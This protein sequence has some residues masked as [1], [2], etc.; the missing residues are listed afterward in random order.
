MLHVGMT[1]RPKSGP[2]T[3]TM[4]H[5]RT[6]TL[7]LVR[8]IAPGKSTLKK[9]KAISLDDVSL[10]SPK[11]RW[12]TLRMRQNNQ[13]KHTKTTMPTMTMVSSQQ[14]LFRWSTASYH[15]LISS[16]PLRQLEKY[17]ATSRT[18]CKRQQTHEIK[19]CTQLQLPQNSSCQHPKTIEMA[20]IS[21]CNFWLSRGS[22]P[23][24]FCEYSNLRR[25]TTRSQSYPMPQ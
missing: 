17:G 4:D 24:D 25:S 19:I 9:K 21:I 1:S 12:W 2:D 22:F 14:S 11:L 10:T 16:P 23:T 7:A 20:G 5:S 8:S 15:A 18:K 6:T 3:P 13:N